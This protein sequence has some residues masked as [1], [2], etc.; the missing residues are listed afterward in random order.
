VHENIRIEGNVIDGGGVSVRGVK[1]L[2]IRGNKT[3]SGTKVGANVAPSCSA[4]QTD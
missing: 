3:P 1:G 4:V 2:A